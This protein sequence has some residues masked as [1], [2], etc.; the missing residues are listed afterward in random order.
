MQSITFQDVLVRRST[1]L[2]HKA[3]WAETVEHLRRFLDTDAAPA[4]QGIMTEG[5]GMVVPQSHIQDVIGEIE[6]GPITKIQ[7]EL[8]RI[9]KSEVAGNVRKQDEDDAEGKAQSRKAKGIPPRSSR[10]RKAAGYPRST[11]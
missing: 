8:L 3:I 6:Q 2:H 11:R 4:K 5:G 9:N 7:E 10:S 1:L